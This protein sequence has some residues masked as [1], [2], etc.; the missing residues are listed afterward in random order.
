MEVL[1]AKLVAM[2]ILGFGCLF[3]GYQQYHTSVFTIIIHHHRH[4]HHICQAIWSYF[5][6][7]KHTKTKISGQCACLLLTLEHPGG[8]TIGVRQMLNLQVGVRQPTRKQ[9]TE[10]IKT[11][12]CRA[13]GRDLPPS[14]F[15][16]WR[17]PCHCSPA[18]SPRGQIA[19]LFLTPYS[20]PI[21]FRF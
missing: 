5:K 13:G 4:H 14:L 21:P 2:L 9:V 8:G 3:I 12:D 16:G 17:S 18:H 1:A 11:P 6:V 7:T 19:A 10:I 20:E 15:R